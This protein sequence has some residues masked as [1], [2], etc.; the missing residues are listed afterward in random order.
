MAGD[1]GVVHV[2][3]RRPTRQEVNRR[4]ER[5]GFVGRRGELAVFR[6]TFAR[7]PEEA[8]FPFLF[9]VRGN[10]GVGKST[11][12][13][14]W[15]STAR[16]QSTVV[17]AFVDDEVHDAVEAMEA[18]SARL[19]R[20]G[21][22]LKR[23]D[24]QLAT[25]RQRRHQAE[26]AVPAPQPDPPGGQA[27]PAASPSSTVAAQ[28][29]LVGLGM[30][31]GVG[32][33]VGAVD[34]QQVALGADR[35]RA[36]LNMRLRSH[37]DVRLVMDPV[38]VLAPVFLEDL[39]EV[40]ERCERV[41]LFFDVYERTGPVLDA[42]LHDIVFGEEYGGL[43]VNVQVVLSGRLRL[44]ARVWG[45]RLG[46]VTEVRLE[47]F[48][49]EE[50]RTLL[51]THGVTDEPSVDLVLRLSGRL[52]LLVDMLARSDASS[53]DSFGD[54]SETAVERF[55]KWEPD[56]RRR[57]AALA[58]ALPLQID[59]DVYRAAVP[60]AAA[61]DYPW[62]RG[63]AFVSTQA[64]RC[65]YHDVVRAAMLRLQ[66]GRSPA[67]WQQAH[68][69]LAD[70]F[71]RWRLG[72]E[73]DLGTA[74]GT[75]TCWEDAVWREHRLNETY[76]RLC[77]NHRTA[78]PDALHQA[79]HAIDHDLATLRRW[80]QILGQA[81]DDTETAVLGAWGRRLE[82]AGE[83]DGASIAVLNVLLA[84]PG[85]GA[86]G[87]ALA[88][89]VRAGEHRIAGDHERALADY[90]LATDIDPDDAR[91]HAGRG[92]TYRLMGRHEEAAAACTRALEL[93]PLD[94]RAVGSR[95]DAYRNLGRHDE[96]LA[97]FA[98]A[99]DLDPGYA[100]AY[101]SRAQVHE[102]SGRPDDA[103]ADYTRAIELNPRYAW[104]FGS[105]AYVH[106]VQG[107]H[108]E[109][110]AD[111]TRA[112]G[113]NP[114]YEWAFASRA[115]VHHIMGEYED[116][117]ADYARAVEIDPDYAWALASRAATYEKLGRHEEALA[118]YTRAIEADPRYEWAL[119][120][121]G[122]LY[123]RLGRYEEALA[124][125][126]LAFEI[127]PRYDWAVLN[128][129][130]VFRRLGRYEEAAADYTRAMEIDPTSG[131][132]VSHRAEMYRRAGLHEEAAADYRL[133]MAAEAPAAWSYAG[134]AQ[135]HL[136]LGRYEEALA[137]CV[138]A[139]E[140]NSD[141]GWYVGLYALSSRLT[142]DEQEAGTHFRRAIR[143]LLADGT[144]DSTR[145]AL[146]LGCVLFM[147]CA[148]Q[149]WERATARCDDLLGRT[150]EAHVIREVLEDLSLLRDVLPS[151]VPGTD[152]LVRR[153][154]DALA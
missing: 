101:G 107:R 62:L 146:V 111:Y 70:V 89:C 60:E 116:A 127:N 66:R 7:D 5:S 117:L 144:G 108:A 32:A 97:D 134:R 69:R 142:G 133:V 36:A 131:A 10:G 6:E 74:A 83:Q 20:Q 45:D 59:E 122:E 130:M 119:T 14:Q 33:F 4:H 50:A 2:A 99:I 145:Q 37:D 129:G 103:V 98:R 85:L 79:V 154:G 12:V 104:A 46:Q 65:R 90:A 115:R 18:V 102:A 42:W 57:E 11:L 150:P 109:A 100:W 3:G 16:E 128:R 9:H 55:L 153:L 113:I 40:A 124:D 147:H 54:P 138:R 152:P 29:G 72:A 132:F 1:P 151:V 34:P 114:R 94:E 82:A 68:T 77:A 135:M 125:H 25:Y 48:T 95:G 47:V 123:R 80:A 91:P 24:K 121:R 31:P 21:H 136:R 73:S 26:S 27:A 44:D 8:D 58:C 106:Q 49:E 149:E 141:D 137:D 81:G 13:R 143:L 71:E 43:P 93:D 61:D 112:L 76:H 41:V 139:V 96:A 38:A 92:E 52:P 30:V 140:I 35:V 87:R 118:D 63:L 28:V 22:P 88:Y 120:G 19:G 15:E 148:L 126:S 105:R 51:A 39:A 17:T 53:G 84:A 67:R 64:G 56:A 110:L 78:L 75:F 23:F 86:P